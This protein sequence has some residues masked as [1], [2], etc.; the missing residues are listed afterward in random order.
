[1]SDTNPED[2]GQISVAELLARNGQ[3]TNLSAGGRR[4]R[5][6][7]GG[8]SVA[9]L[10]GEIPVVR[11]EPGNRSAVVV[12]TPAPDASGPETPET[13]DVAP[14]APQSSDAPEDDAPAAGSSRP[15]PARPQTTRPTPF[16]PAGKREKQQPE[17]E[18]LSGSTTV[19][20]D[21]LNRSHDDTERSKR[22]AVSTVPASDRLPYGS[23]PAEQGRAR[24]PVGFRAS[25]QVEVVE[26][27]TDVAPRAALVDVDDVA[28]TAVSPRIRRTDDKEAGSADKDISIDE[29][30]EVQAAAATETV[31]LVKPEID[32]EP[33]TATDV[34]ADTETASDA[35]ADS[36]TAASRTDRRAAAVKG[37]GGAVRQWL[38]LI[39]QAVVS[40]AVG[41]LLF[42]GF[43]QLWDVLPWVALVL[44]VLVIVGLVA[45]VRILRRTDDLISIVIA[46]AVGVFVTLG[47]LAFQLSTG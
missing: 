7:K 22:P 45:V 23:T 1:M 26:P 43:E 44:S 8:I 46:I 30:T 15:Q 13:P 35:E 42:K 10:T 16:Q 6:V 25:R 24:K 36:A 14:A 4:R 29:P 21:L 18:L 39:G 33:K 19:A 9:E 37:K 3:K 27:N 17:P 20:G 38:V 40:I 31:D 41:A 11:D 12:E 47:P 2:T 28:K 32:D 5:G 34:E